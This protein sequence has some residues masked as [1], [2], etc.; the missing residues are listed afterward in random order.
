MNYTSEKYLQIRGK[1]ETG[2]K[3]SDQRLIGKLVGSER[4]M[5]KMESCCFMMM[6]MLSHHSSIT[7]KGVNLCP[8]TLRSMGR[9]LGQ[10]SELRRWNV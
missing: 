1:K 5:K 2:S 3:E 7:Y 6:M 8:I 10:R 4:E 9:W